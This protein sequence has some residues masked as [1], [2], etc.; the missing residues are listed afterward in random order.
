MALRQGHSAGTEELEAGKG[1]FI[2]EE[3][4]HCSVKGL[5]LGTFRPTAAGGG[6]PENDP[7]ALQKRATRDPEIQVTQTT[8]LLVCPGG[9][10]SNERSGILQQSSGGYLRGRQSWGAC[11]EEGKRGPAGVQKYSLLLCVVAGIGVIPGQGPVTAG[12]GRQ[13]AQLGI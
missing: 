7:S 13:R 8:P 6:S 10:V 3:V 5:Q 9:W 2:M 4:I 11:G 12:Q 1:S